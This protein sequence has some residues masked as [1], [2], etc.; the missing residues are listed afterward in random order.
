MSEIK[1][2]TT[3]EW[4]E[5][6]D[7]EGIVGITERAQQTYGSIVFV[8]LPLVG[9]ELEQEDTIGRIEV[10][11]GGTFP[12]YAPVTGEIIEVNF[13]LEDDPDLIN[14]SP[15]GDGWIC[16]MSIEGPRELDILMGPD[17]YEEYEEENELDDDEYVGETD[18]YDE[19]EN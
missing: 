17:E 9:D 18:F 11:D 16:R 19:E 6:I 8:E 5:I 14:R 15:E 7:S 3:H 4:I 12:V 1:Y 10:A 13:A 2:T